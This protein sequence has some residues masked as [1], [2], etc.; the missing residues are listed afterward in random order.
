MMS[1]Q[2]LRSPILSF[3]TKEVDREQMD[4]RRMQPH[5]GSFL[6]LSPQFSSVSGT[7]NVLP[8]EIRVR[9]VTL[10]PG[11]PSASSGHVSQATRTMSESPQRLRSRKL[12]FRVATKRL[13]LSDWRKWTK[14]DHS[15]SESFS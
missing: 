15:A 13:S 10:S 4:K 5:R 11:L 14:E 3:A 12:S 6:L 2:R 1:P 9:T 8:R 7:I